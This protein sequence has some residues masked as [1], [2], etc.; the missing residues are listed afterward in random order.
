MI[1]VVCKVREF[2]MK[3]IIYF[4][5]SDLNV[6]TSFKLEGFMVNLVLFRVAFV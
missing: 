1:V 3:T 4:V 6:S 5:L 2:I